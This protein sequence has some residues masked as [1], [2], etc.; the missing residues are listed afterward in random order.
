MF[1]FFSG[2]N[3]NESSSQSKMSIFVAILA[4]ISIVSN[5][6]QR[7]KEPTLFS[8]K[9]GKKLYTYSMC[10]KYLAL[11]PDSNKR[12]DESVDLAHRAHGRFIKFY[13]Y[14]MWTAMTYAVMIALCDEL[15]IVASHD[16]VKKHIMKDPAFLIYNSF[17]RDKFEKFLKNKG[18]SENEY[19]DLIKEQLQIIQLN[20]LLFSVCSL[21]PEMLDLLKRALSAKRSIRVYHAPLEKLL[22]QPSARELLHCYEKNKEKF[23]TD[24]LYK[25]RALSIRRAD[26]NQKDYDFIDVM[27][28]N[29]NFDGILKSYSQHT[30]LLDEALFCDYV[31]LESEKELKKGSCLTLNFTGSEMMIGQVIDLKE[32]TILPFDQVKGQVRSLYVSLNPPKFVENMSIKPVKLSYDFATIDELQLDGLPLD[33]KIKSVLFDLSVGEKRILSINEMA[34]AIILD[35]IKYTDNMSFSEEMILRI[36]EELIQKALISQTYKDNAVESS[37]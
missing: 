20:Y 3:T 31:P 1:N 6:F 37:N 23:K 11:M 28:R 30:K 36:L 29:D 10:R 22:K 15:G 35:E 16:D 5:L 21:K 14:I 32:S 4:G 24:R 2:D 25:I 17:S 19:Y 7:Y 9:Q 18:V 8:I 26:L 33:K 13:D 12:F 27:I 34:Y